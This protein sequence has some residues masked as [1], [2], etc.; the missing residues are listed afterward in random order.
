MGKRFTRVAA[1][2]F[3]LLLAAV[4]GGQDLKRGTAK[5][6]GEKGSLVELGIS[7]VSMQETETQ[8]QIILENR[9]TQGGTEAGES[10]QSGNDGG[11][12]GEAGDGLICGDY[13][14]GEGEIEQY[15]GTYRITEFWPTIY[16]GA[17][18]YD[19]LPEQEADMMLGRIVEIGEEQLITYDS[20]RWLGIREGG[21]AFWGNYLIEKISI[22]Q[23]QYE[24][25][26]LDP[27]TK[28]YEE[29]EYHHL[30]D[31]I[32]REY[33]EVI[34][35]R[36][37][38][39]VEESWYKHEYYVMRDGI[40]MYSWL[41]GQYFYLEKLDE[42]LDRGMLQNELTGEDTERILQELY[43]V[44]SVKKFLPTKFYPVLDSCGDL[45]LPQEEA[46]MMIGKEIVI[47]EDLFVTYDN[48]R[49]PNSLTAGR[50]MDKFVLEAAEIANPDYRLKIQ[51]RD[52]IYGLRDE[53]L[54]EEL[55]QDT[56]IQINVYPGYGSRMDW[57]E[58]LPQLYL[59]KDGRMIMYAMG[60][61]FLIEKCPICHQ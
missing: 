48:Y 15:Y 31:R 37:M 56:Y 49:L 32:S 36:I 45:R 42:E 5:E 33:Y 58:T 1:V 7:E 38:L 61:Y 23:P 34:E 28:W 35:G 26:P 21:F 50:A 59:L 29:M 18:K 24:W 11:D 9:N 40:I 39:Q 43:G 57:S 52:E 6:Q 60:E 22:L 46:D 13:K 51:P 44:Y 19:C 10:I 20:F 54:P 3:L 14:Y 4:E 8:L 2:L 12:G 16:Y 47:E 17:T 27:D 55:V 53:M 30:S 25:E 41:T